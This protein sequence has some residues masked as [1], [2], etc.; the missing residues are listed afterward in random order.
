ME[1]QQGHILDV[2]NNTTKT[3]LTQLHNT[4]DKMTKESVEKIEQQVQ[5]QYQSVKNQISQLVTEATTNVTH[6][7]AQDSGETP[8]N[9]DKVHAKPPLM[10]NRRFP[11]VPYFDLNQPS[12]PR[13]NPYDT[14]SQPLSPDI[15][16]HDV[17]AEWDRFGPTD[18]MQEHDIRPVPQLFAH[19]LLSQVKV[20]YTGFEST[21]TWYY[22]LRSSV[23]QYGILLLSID[24]ISLNKSLCP[25]KYC[26]TRIDSARYRDMANAL[27]QLLVLPDT[28]AYEYTE[29][30]NI[31]HHNATT[32]DGYAT[33]YKIMEQIHP[34]LNQ[35]A[36]LR[37]PSSATC[38]DIHKYFRQ[39]D[40]YLLHNRLMGVDFTTRRKVNLF[41][42]G[43]E[44]SYEVA[45]NRLQ[46]H[47]MTWK[48]DD[49]EPPDALKIPVLARTVE[50]IMQESVHQPVVRAIHH[51]SYPPK[52]HKLGST[53]DPDTKHL[54]LPNRQYQDVQCKFCGQYGHKKHTCDKMAVWIRLQEA[55][56]QLD[57][58][59]KAQL[60]KNHTEMMQ[61]YRTRRFQRLKSTVR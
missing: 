53:R 55:S 32:S 34:V 10:R 20:P 16:T 50:K 57:E 21:Y 14:D 2:I 40:S 29:I 25:Q 12:K 3:S 28:V 44:P 13:Y 41:I 18:T 35:D 38:T 1:Q 33:L 39:Y 4:I 24:Q 26:G 47:M 9:Q 22:T 61:N 19:K 51:C 52:D 59:L 15:I 54:A 37:Q 6:A 30:R 45:I 7:T 56:K 17:E 27:Y 8:A 58:K 42:E 36:K 46:Q 49:P 5:D 48:K 31:L 11:N 43:L 60:L 23:Q